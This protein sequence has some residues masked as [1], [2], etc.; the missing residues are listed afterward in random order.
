MQE[1][2]QENYY[3]HTKSRA[4]RAGTT[5]GNI[6]GHNKP[7]LPHMKPEKTAKLS[8]D[9]LVLF[10]INLN[11]SQIFPSEKHLADQIYERKYQAY[12]H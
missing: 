5:V 9:L 11:K 8:Q 6:H 1:V 7:L 3:I 12:T 10:C 4:Q 2:L